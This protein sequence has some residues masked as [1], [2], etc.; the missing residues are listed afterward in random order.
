MARAIIKPV[1]AVINSESAFIKDELNK[2]GEYELATKYWFW[3]C[4][5]TLLINSPEWVNEK[6]EQMQDD[7]DAIDR[8]Q[9]MPSWGT[10]GT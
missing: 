3:A 6:I 7:L 5:R 8:Q 9:T 2:A 10:Y 4:M 1:R